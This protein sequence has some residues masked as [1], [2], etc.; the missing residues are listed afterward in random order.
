MFCVTNAE[1]WD[2]ALT[3]EVHW[4]DSFMYFLHLPYIICNTLALIFP[5][6]IAL[7]SATKL[8]ALPTL[9][10]CPR[11]YPRYKLHTDPTPKLIE[12]VACL[13]CRAPRVDL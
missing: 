9:A 11:L 2:G 6:A 1:K 3:R 7:N 5:T 13:H 12:C 8:S 10:L 4:S